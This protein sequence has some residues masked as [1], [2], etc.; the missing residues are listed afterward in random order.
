MKPILNLITQLILYQ[1]HKYF[2][3]SYLKI[4]NSEFSDSFSYD[5]ILM[6]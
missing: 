2:G 4:R 1:T 6:H 5:L 3:K